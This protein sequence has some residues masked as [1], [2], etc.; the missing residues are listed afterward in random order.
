MH[1][2][3]HKLLLQSLWELLQKL[4]DVQIFSYIDQ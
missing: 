1:F 4:W 3:V 2:N